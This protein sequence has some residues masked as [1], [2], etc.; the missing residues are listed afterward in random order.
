MEVKKKRELIREK[1]Y[2]YLLSNTESIED[3]KVF[4]SAC[5]VVIKQ[6]FL[7]RM[8]E[9]KVE[10]L[11]L[12]ELQA[13]VSAVRRYNDLFDLVGKYSILEAMDLL[14]GLTVEMDATLKKELETRKLE[15][16]KV[17]LL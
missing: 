11:K 1:L 14:D 10:E 6:Q 2:P 5:S 13:E 8:K 9:V 7:G 16:L 12:K 17:E 4:V 3:A 15:T